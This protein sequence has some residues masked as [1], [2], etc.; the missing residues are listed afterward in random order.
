MNKNFA[1]DIVD[2]QINVVSTAVMGLS[3]SCA[4]CHD[5][6]HDPVSTRDYYA[7]AG[8]FSSTETLYGRAAEEKL[9]APPTQLHQLVSAGGDQRKSPTVIKNTPQFPESYATAIDAHKP[10]FHASLDVVPP[11]WLI[12]GDAQFTSE[13]FATVDNATMMGEVA[14]SGDA[15]TVAF[16][17]KNDLAN[18]KR[19]ITAYLFSRGTRGKQQTGDHLGIGGTHDKARTGK[20]FVFNG[21]DTKQSIGGVTVIPPGSWN[22][23]V[24]VRSGDRV[25]VYLNGVPEAEF[26]GKL[27]ATIGDAK[28]YFV[29]ARSDNFAPLKGNVAHFAIFDRELQAEEIQK[30]HSASGEPQGV[31]TPL[32]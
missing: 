6:K 29:A 26:T 18:N 13:N 28:S 16:W 25:S 1:M 4:R 31:R 30:L 2:D 3:V 5:H 27:P 32:S 8:I 10:S 20:L 14:E 24:M 12:E 15:Y 21:S 23:I 22:H 9:T 7:L 17:F 11:S 19:P